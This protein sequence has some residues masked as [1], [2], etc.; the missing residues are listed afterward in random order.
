M[1]LT[2]LT[3]TTLCPSLLFEQIAALDTQLLICSW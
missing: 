3:L 1:D 2:L